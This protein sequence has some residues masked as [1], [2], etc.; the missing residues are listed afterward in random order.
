MSII[1]P[2]RNEENVLPFLLQD[3]RNQSLQASE[4]IVVDD[5]SEDATAQIAS[6]LGAKLIS[7]QEKPNGW[8]GKSWACQQGAE[9][10][11]G[12]VLLFLDS[13]VRLGKDGLRRLM[14]AHSDCKCTI[15]VQPYHKTEKTFEQ[16]SMIFNLIQIAAN[17]SALPKPIKIGLCGPLILIS[18]ADYARVGGHRIVRNSVIEDLSLGLELTNAGI[19][20][21]LFMGDADVSYRMYSGGLIS[22]F[23]GWIKNLASGA[24]KTS[25][26]VLLLVFFWIASLASV[27]IQLIKS[28]ITVDLPWLIVYAVL[29]IIWMLIL[30]RLTRRIGHF[31]VW[32]I[33]FYP[34]LIL[35]LFGVFAVSLF[36]KIFG[37]KT[38][39]KGRKVGAGENRCE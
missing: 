3:L 32:A 10:A 30:T 14:Q 22:L 29:L 4:I 15:S 13:D 28:A 25:W 16:F 2:A 20:Y 18:R 11:Q 12:E 8:T 34:I 1:I 21:Q 9:A 26:L 24:A 23:Q 38:N 37:L 17:G 27:P 19:P 36:R 5:E 7:L 35:A 33:F 31:Q 6:S 39:W